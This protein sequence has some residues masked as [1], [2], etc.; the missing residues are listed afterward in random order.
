MWVL[1]TYLDIIFDTILIVP[2][3]QCTCRFTEL[4]QDSPEVATGHP[5]LPQWQA[6]KSFQETLRSQGRGGVSG[7]S[8]ES[9]QGSTAVT[10]PLLSTAS[11]S[12]DA[13]NKSPPSSPTQVGVSVVPGGQRYVHVYHTM[14]AHSDVLIIAGC[15]ATVLPPEIKPE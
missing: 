5:R 8:S 2:C 7:G 6:R 11:K 13:K 1:Q 15:S 9:Q 12:S 10:Q 4:P 14:H 3:A